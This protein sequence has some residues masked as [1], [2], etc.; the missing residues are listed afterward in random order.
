MLQ[1]LGRVVATQ[2]ASL[3]KT[4]SVHFPVTMSMLVVQLKRRSTIFEEE[5]K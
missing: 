5:K 4:M 3:K 2:A 1:S